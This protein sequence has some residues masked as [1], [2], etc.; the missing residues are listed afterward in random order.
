MTNFQMPVYMYSKD[1]SIK[2]KTVLPLSIYDPIVDS[3]IV[4]LNDINNYM[5]MCNWDCTIFI[6]S[7]EFEL[8]DD[9]VIPSNVKVHLYVYVE[10]IVEIFHYLDEITIRTCDEE[11]LYKYPNLVIENLQLVG[12]GDLSL[13]N[14]KFKRLLI[15]KY[16]GIPNI[17]DDNIEV[18]SLRLDRAKHL[19]Q[20]VLN[21]FAKIDKL[22]ID[23]KS[24]I[25]LVVDEFDQINI[26]KLIIYGVYNKNMTLKITNPY[27]RKIKMYGRLYRELN[28]P[29]KINLDLEDNYTLLEVKIDDENLAN[30]E[31]VDK[32]LKRNNSLLIDRRFKRVKVA[33]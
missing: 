18:L 6:Y 3:N 27:I 20:D 15:D 24:F 1:L 31:E 22:S 16:D 12:E 33:N 25:G 7:G 23:Y 32:W 26:K 10:S 17:L 8:I 9:V 4:Y 13:P 2:T 11:Y 14:Y 30:K 28:K 21:K 5:E 19:T 29:L